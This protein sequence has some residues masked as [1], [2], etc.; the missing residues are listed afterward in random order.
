MAIA[1]LGKPLLNSLEPIPIEDRWM[2]ARADLALE[3]DLAD[4]E[5]IAQEIGERA[6]GEGDAADGAPIGEMADLGDDPVLTKVRQEEPDAAEVEVAPEDS[7]DPLSLLLF[8]DQLLVPAHIPERHHAADPQP[9]A[10]GGADLLAD[11]LAGDLTLEL[12]KG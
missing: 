12:G 3:A 2:L 6:S 11:P 1:L 8:D 5:A 4:V 9:L 7:A 10:L